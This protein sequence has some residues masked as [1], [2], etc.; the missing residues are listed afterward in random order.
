MPPKR[1]VKASRKLLEQISEDSE[2]VEELKESS[3][4]S[5]DLKYKVSKSV[6]VFF[7]LPSGQREMILDYPMV[8]VDR[9]AYDM[10]KENTDSDT[11]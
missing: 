5:V 8:F 1:E 9:K 10:H 2:E 6:V 4:D 7:T 3:Y 11:E